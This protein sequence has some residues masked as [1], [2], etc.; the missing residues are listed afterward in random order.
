MILIHTNLILK[1]F[2]FEFSNVNYNS[3]E[4]NNI[5][6]S[7]IEFIGPK[8]SLQNLTLNANIYKPDW[9]TNEKLEDV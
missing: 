8:V 5:F 6:E 1:E 3:L 9:I 4:N 7:T 2:Q